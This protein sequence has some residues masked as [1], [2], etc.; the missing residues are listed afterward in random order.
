MSGN[1]ARS[2][3]LAH[4]SDVH[5]DDDDRPAQRGGLPGLAAVLRTAVARS[6]DI[7]L[8]AGDTFDH[9]RVG[10]PALT[11]VRRILAAAPIHVV[12]LP[13]NHDPLLGQ[14]I[15][16]RAGLHDLPQVHILG[17]T[18]EESF[19]LPDHG[20][21]IHGRAHRD[22]ADMPPMPEPRPRVLPRQV[23]I[24]HGHYVPASEWER[25]SH[26]AWR[27]SDAAL[28]AGGA[29][30]IALGHWDRPTAVGNEAARAY[31]SGSPDLAE[32]VNIVRLTT[33][34]PAQVTRTPLLWA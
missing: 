17:L 1:E 26:R 9:G 8:L 29:D 28:S 11:G 21:E 10:G 24:A 18:E 4:S 12:V 34:E 7:L 23:I 20:I 15:F 22:F 16:E 14:S 19:Y 27:I 30:Y 31:Y 33:S 3:I 13:G 25:Q 5:V 2:L 6:A 32:T